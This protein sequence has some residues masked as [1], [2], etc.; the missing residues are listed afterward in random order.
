VCVVEVYVR[1]NY[2]EVWFPNTL[3]PSV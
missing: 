3:K 2:S 1:T